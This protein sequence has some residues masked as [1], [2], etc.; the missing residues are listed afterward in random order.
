MLLKYTQKL[1]SRVIDSH[2]PFVVCLINKYNVG[3]SGR[4]LD[5]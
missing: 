3:E 2:S 1:K 5:F 4:M